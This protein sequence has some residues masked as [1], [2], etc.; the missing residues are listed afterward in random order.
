MA[1]GQVLQSILSH[2]DFDCFLGPLVLD[3]C[4]SI[5]AELEVAIADGSLTLLN[6]LDMSPAEFGSLLDHHNL[7]VGETECMA[8]LAINDHQVSC[9]DGAARKV[10]SALYGPN[11][12]T[13]T[14]G[15]LVLAVQAN[16]LAPEE[17]FSSYQLM[18]SAGGY[19]PNISA[20][21]FKALVG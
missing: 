11:R 20:T 13:G 12:V 9:D 17:A 4:P 6:D 2:D 1:H 21:D 15:L 10:L 19:L 5:R 14:L 16:I 18:R 8:F 7:G 3:E